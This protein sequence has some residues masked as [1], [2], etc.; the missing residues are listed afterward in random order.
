MIHDPADETLSIPLSRN[1]HRTHPYSRFPLDIALLS[2][3]SQLAS[4]CVGSRIDLIS[5]CLSMDLISGP[6]QGCSSDS[7]DL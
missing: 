3:P 7:P 4:F 5:R 2:I 1:W 6:D